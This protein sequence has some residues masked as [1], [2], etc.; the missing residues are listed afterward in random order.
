MHAAQST[1]TEGEIAGEIVREIAREISHLMRAASEFCSRSTRPIRF[2]ALRSSCSRLRWAMA[3]AEALWSGSSY[4]TRGT[5][6]G[7]G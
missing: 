6:E 1:E 2:I 3:P 5:R 7:E 4:L